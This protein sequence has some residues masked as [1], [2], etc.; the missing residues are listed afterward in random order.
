MRPWIEQLSKSGCLK[1][2]TRKKGECLFLILLSFLNAALLIDPLPFEINTQRTHFFLME[3]WFLPD[4][5]GEKTCRSCKIPQLCPR[6]Q[7]KGMRGSA[8]TGRFKGPISRF[9]A[10]RA[11]GSAGHKVDQGKGGKVVHTFVSA[12]SALAACLRLPS[13]PFLV[14]SCRVFCISLVRSFKDAVCLHFYLSRSFARRTSQAHRQ[15]AQSAQK[16]RN[17]LPLLPL[18]LAYAV[19]CAAVRETSTETRNSAL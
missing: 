11:D 6:A 9:G 4:F 8:S 1:G 7:N 3:K 15:P 2:N 5:V 18:P 12:R 16:R 13:L 17:G 10:G 14:C 19:A